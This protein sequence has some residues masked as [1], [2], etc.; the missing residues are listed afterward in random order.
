MIF[1][2]LTYVGHNTR[3]STCRL[4]GYGTYILMAVRCYS[5]LFYEYLTASVTM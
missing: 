2:M 5:F 3:L 1:I 4:L